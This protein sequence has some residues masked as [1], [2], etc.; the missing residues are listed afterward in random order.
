MKN[1]LPGLILFLLSSAVAA[2][3]TITIGPGA[4]S[5]IVAGG[6]GREDRSIEV[7]YYRPATLTPASP[8]LMVLPGAGRNG[9]D[10]RDAW[11]EAAERHGVLILSPSYDETHYPNY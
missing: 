4:G 6:E 1:L 5:F 10:Y 3:S 8:V 7:H 2:G 11:K 9:G